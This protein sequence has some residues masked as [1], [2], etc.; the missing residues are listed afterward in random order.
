[1][2]SVLDIIVRTIDQASG[3]AKGIAGAV[4]GIATAAVAASA[5][6]ATAAVGI[7]VVSGK[8]AADFEQSL[9]NTAAATGATKDQLADLRRE[10][11]AIGKD[12]SKSASESAEAMGELVKA[13]LSIET[14]VNGAARAVVQLA[15]ATG[16]DVTD[17]AILVS[18]SLNTFQK[19]GLKAADVANIVAKAANASAI[20]TKDVSFALAAVGPVAAQAGLKMQDFAT[21]IGIL[22]NNALKGSDAGTSLKTMLMRLTAPTDE[23]KA[24]FA[25]LGVNVFDAAGKTRGFRDI[26]GD[27]QVAIKDSSEEQK[28]ATLTTLFGS[29]A[30]RAAN[31]LLD[32]GVEGWDAFNASMGAAPDVAAQSAARLATL[33]GRI[34]SLK[35]TLE[36]VGILL[37]EKLL[38]PLTSLA[39]AATAGISYLLDADWSR[40][41]FAFGII[42]QNAQ[43]MANAILPMFGD[44]ADSIGP[45]IVDTVNE[46]ALAL[47]HLSGVVR[48]VFLQQIMPTVTRAVA[49]I[50]R[51]FNGDWSAA[52][53]EW[54][55]PVVENLGNGLA[56]LYQNILE[57]LG[58]TLVKVVNTL[59]DWTGAF[60]DWLGPVWPQLVRQFGTFLDRMIGWFYT[61]A[62]PSIVGQLAQWGAALVSWVVPRIPG[63]LAELLKL[64][65]ELDK[66]L[67]GRLPEIKKVLSAWADRFLAWVNEEVLPKLPGMLDGVIREI[68]KWAGGNQSA[69][70]S[71]G[72][73]LGSALIKGV[74]NGMRSMS[75]PL[76]KFDLKMVESGI[77]GVKI[78]SLG[79]GVTILPIGQLL[80]ALAEGGITNG[81][82]IAVIGDNPS[83]KE[84]IVPLEKAGAMGFGGGGGVHLHFHAPVYGL[85]DFQNKVV[86]AMV[87]AQKQGR[88]TGLVAQT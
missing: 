11:L 42:A 15:E 73:Q 84:A 79:Y 54:V 26:L 4:G 24:I 30:I 39:E 55:A 65:Q 46:G 44:S 83:G 63:M 16:S 25:E 6:V 51:I 1:M 37:G 58:G 49:T 12:T 64:Q 36:T 3:P 23:A 69:V 75:W 76:P 2:A 78:P 17:M 56:D 74:Y 70:E 80:P 67:I 59:A 38:P 61:N 72:N 18:N 62:L 21:A 77:P 31:I 87:V 85:S 43:A 20:G 33:N 27:L 57:G 29:D 52:F 7:G 13:G 82:T 19:D 40:L 71:V 41:S 50:Q 60:L 10:A 47:A 35:G 9:A 5:A 48:D 14:V 53:T 68:Q 28:A 34:E 88:V 8:L 32:A 45:A 66:W 81:P 86:E 22:G